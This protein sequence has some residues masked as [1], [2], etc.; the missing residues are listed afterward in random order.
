MV[1]WDRETVGAPQDM[2]ARMMNV[3][4]VGV[5]P[6]GEVRLSEQDTVE[7]W[8][9]SLW[10]HYCD[11]DV[12]WVDVI[13]SNDQGVTIGYED[14]VIDVS[15]IMRVSEWSHPGKSRNGGEHPPPVSIR[16]RVTAYD[17]DRGQLILS[18]RAALV[19]L[20]DSGRAVGESFRGTVSGIG[21]TG[22][23]VRI[24][25]G[26][27][28]FVDESEMDWRQAGD[29]DLEDLAIEVGQELPV[30]MLPPG[31]ERSEIRFSARRAAWPM[32]RTMFSAGQVVP[33]VAIAVRAREVLLCLPD[34]VL[35]RAARHRVVKHIEGKRDAGYPIYVISRGDIVPVK[36]VSVNHQQVRIDVSYREGRAEASEG[37]AWK[38]DDHG[39]VLR[40]PDEVRAI[41]PAESAAIESVLER[42]REKRQAVGRP[43]RWRS[44]DVRV[45]RTIE[46]TRRVV[47]GRRPHDGGQN[48]DVRRL[49]GAPEVRYMHDR[50]RR[51]Q[52]RPPD[53]A[54]CD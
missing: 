18:E 51:I 33:G 29:L 20:L 49:R 46:R 31:Q 27:D 13:E 9:R 21:Q 39:R 41:F 11:Q 4:A 10:Q 53:G 7:P 54:G 47:R 16:V 43:T 25:A 23:Y 37:G 19:T 17:R 6:S 24:A 50:R 36:I 2:V 12:F 35:G 8:R 22:V 15:H 14:W 52:G 3:V 42:R 30:V 40:I 5:L 38:F 34:G 48:G 44:L 26:I 28:G 1:W 45:L 32:V